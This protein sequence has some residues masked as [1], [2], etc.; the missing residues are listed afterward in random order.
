L[1]CGGA[2]IWGHLPGDALPLNLYTIACY[3]ATF[4]SVVIIK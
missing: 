3:G 4:G 2:T 1:F